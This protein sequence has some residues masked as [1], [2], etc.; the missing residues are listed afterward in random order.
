[1]TKTIH[2]SALPAI[3]FGLAALVNLAPSVAIAQDRGPTERVSYAD[4]DLT[5]PAG[6]EVL[7][8]RLDRAVK[9]VCGSPAAASLHTQRRIA[10]CVDDTW[11]TVRP[12]RHVA[13]A[14]AAERR[15]NLDFARNAAR[16]TPVIAL[17]K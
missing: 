9:R 16:E 10:Q 15:D 14:Q 7:D 6:V 5:S 2:K 12:Q 13:I 1:M 17:S 3:A 4:L 8:R 11:D